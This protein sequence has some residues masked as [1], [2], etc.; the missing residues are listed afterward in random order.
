MLTNSRSGEVAGVVE[1]VEAADPAPAAVV[2]EVAD[3]PHPTP[4]RRRQTLV[5][6]HAVAQ[7][8]RQH[9]AAAIVEVPQFHIR[10][11]L[12]L[13]LEVLRLSCCL[14]QHWRSSSLPSG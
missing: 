5:V 13:R 10:L 1:E 11:G 7:A 3:Q 8:P 2:A 14:L 9:T 6:E 4:S 12:G